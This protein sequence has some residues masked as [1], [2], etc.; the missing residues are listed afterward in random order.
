MESVLLNAQYEIALSRLKLSGFGIAFLSIIYYYSFRAWGDKVF[1]FDFFIYCS[2][3]LFLGITRFFLWYFVNRI[4]KKQVIYLFFT[5][6]TVSSA[7]WGYGAIRIFNVT[8]NSYELKML[9][10]AHLVMLI[11]LINAIP[12][13]FR[14]SP[15]AFFL[16]LAIYYPSLMLLVP[17][18]FENSN[19]TFGI[20]L[21]IVLF[22][23]MI[24]PAYLNNWKKSFQSLKQ[25]QELQMIIDS[26]PGGVSELK[27]GRYVRAN[28]YVR[29]QIIKNRNLKS[30]SEI[31]GQPLGYLHEDAPWV[32]KVK[33]F[34]KDTRSF[35]LTEEVLPTVNGDKIHLTA[36]SRIENN[37]IVLA[38]VDIQDFIN[39]RNE[40]DNQKIKAIENSK[41]AGIGLMAAGI[42][43]E[44]NNP[45]SVIQTRTDLL[46]RELNKTPTDLD[47]VKMHLGKIPPMIKRVSK[48]IDTL[49]RLSRD[50]SNDDY[51]NVT[52]TSI[53]DDCLTLSEEKFKKHS[54]DFTVQCETQVTLNCRPTE[55]SQ[56]IINALNNSVYAISELEEKWI[57][58]ETLILNN[59]III[60]LIDSGRGILPENRNKI[61]TPLFTTKPTGEGTGLGL[62]LSKQIA[63]NHGGKL[64]FDYEHPNTC[65]VLE[66][67]L[68]APN[69]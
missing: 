26:F 41:L 28:R 6:I 50:S 54:I 5:L 33:A 37:H 19:A 24:T 39:A 13:F 46:N 11:G 30:E 60:K 31:I 8:E 65:L 14:Y 15:K 21:I 32:R 40:A 44:I 10:M 38:T 56:I 20:Y 27:D 62:S 69:S 49:R 47:K 67:P 1:G 63:E 43:H 52:L 29:N 18:I 17:E 66:L 53:I 25:E 55:I 45:L 42:A 64:Y 57:K 22:A 58:I 61:M 59:N 36:M 16:N 51:E 9:G 4:S 34:Q 12:Q 7:W 23:Y 2:I 48:I 68:V 3:H 35:L